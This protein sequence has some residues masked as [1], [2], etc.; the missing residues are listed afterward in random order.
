MTVIICEKCGK[1]VKPV[2]PSHRPYL[3]FYINNPCENPDC[4][5]KSEVVKVE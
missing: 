4:R 3:V 1:V 5:G 2:K